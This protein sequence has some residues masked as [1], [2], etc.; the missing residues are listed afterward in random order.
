[1][2]ERIPRLL[3]NHSSDVMELTGWVGEPALQAFPTQAPAEGPGPL[4]PAVLLLS[5]LLAQES[6]S[7][8][9]QPQGPQVPK[10]VRRLPA[11]GC[12]SRW[13][14]WGHT[15]QRAVLVGLAPREGTAASSAATP[16]TPLSD[17][18]GGHQSHSRQPLLLDDATRLSI[19][20]MPYSSEVE[21]SV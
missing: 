15:P 7:S 5:R 1:M 16:G 4:E 9:S 19:P 13:T 6:D 12:P 17:L 18:K 11:A 21:K 20:L 8:P 3:Y 14:C 2:E 10:I